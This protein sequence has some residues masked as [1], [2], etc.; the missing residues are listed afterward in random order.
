M[1]LSHLPS[2]P[3]SYNLIYN[4]YSIQEFSYK[5]VYQNSTAIKC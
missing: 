4:I 3:Q 1:E 2:V 5:K